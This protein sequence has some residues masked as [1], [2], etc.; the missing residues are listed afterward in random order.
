V[1][2]PN[3]IEAM[4]RTLA[5][6]LRRLESE[7][8]LFFAGRLP[9]PPWETRTRVERLLKRCDRTYIDNTA[10]RFRLGTLQARYASFLDLWERQ[11]R[12]YDEG[13]SGRSQRARARSR[14]AP[15]APDAPAPAEAPAPAS[16]AEKACVLEQVAI[17]DPSSDDGKLRQL[18]DTLARAQHEAGERPISY[19]RF[20]RLVQGRVR[21]LRRSG[22]SETAFRVEVNE[23]KVCLKVRGE[24]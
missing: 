5:A 7:Y 24:T 4:L 18:H 22:N 21:Q 10:Q 23:G 3:E 13:R 9:R 8:T 20:S 1:S 6:D 14:G 19:E 16:A 2:E 15:T 17:R 12:A 11:Q